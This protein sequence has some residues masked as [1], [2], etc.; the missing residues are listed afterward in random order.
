LAHL[1]AKN[2]I[3]RWA[4]KRHMWQHDV[5]DRLRLREVRKDEP[6][7]VPPHAVKR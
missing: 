4:A 3:A 1:H 6:R 5:L 7:M 2:A